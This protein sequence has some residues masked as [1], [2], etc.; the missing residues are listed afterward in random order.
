MLTFYLLM[1]DELRAM[2][3]NQTGPNDEF[4]SSYAADAERAF[5][6]KVAHGANT[7]NTWLGGA[8]GPSGS[9]PHPDEQRPL[10]R[11]G[12]ESDD[13]ESPRNLR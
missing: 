9:A 3:P 12:S 8:S 11:R 5:V 6:N 7:H 1:T 4:V 13:V 2:A 10:S